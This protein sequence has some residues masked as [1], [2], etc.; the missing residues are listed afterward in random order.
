MVIADHNSS[1]STSKLVWL[2]NANIIIDSKHN[3]N[4]VNKNTA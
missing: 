1:V 2:R 4:T 3:I